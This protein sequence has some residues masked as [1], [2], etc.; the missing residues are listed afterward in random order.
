M[1]LVNKVS[2]FPTAKC[3]PWPARSL[4]EKKQIIEGHQTIYLQSILM[5]WT[6][7]MTSGVSN[8]KNI[9]HI[10]SPESSHLTLFMKISRNDFGM[11]VLSANAVTSA[12][13][14][15]DSSTSSPC[16]LC[17]L[18]DAD[19]I[20]FFEKFCEY[21]FLLSFILRSFPATE[22]ASLGK[23]VIFM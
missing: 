3:N 13:L 19:A 16:P 14:A 21:S 1:C 7:T 2:E 23:Q 12:L 17:V 15:N 9:A 6:S 8:M 10:Y 20:T 22:A 5:V 11:S 18:G 4:Y